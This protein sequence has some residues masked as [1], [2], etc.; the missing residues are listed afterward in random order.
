MSLDTKD[1]LDKGTLGT[2]RW[3]HLLKRRLPRYQWSYLKVKVGY[4]FWLTAMS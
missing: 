4:A 2:K 3:T 1:I